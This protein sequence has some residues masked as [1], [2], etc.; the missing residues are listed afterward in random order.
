MAE[1]VVNEVFE[2]CAND[3]RPFDEVSKTGSSQ[4]LRLVIP[5][6][7]DL[8]VVVGRSTEIFPQPPSQALYRFIISC[9]P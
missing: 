8:L 6:F 5:E 1:R 4:Q 3:T 7:S 9:L 2:S